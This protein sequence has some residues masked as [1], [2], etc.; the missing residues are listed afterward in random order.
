MLRIAAL[1]LPLIAVAVSPGTAQAQTPPAQGQ[2]GQPARPGAPVP[3]R[4]GECA[5][6]P[7]GKAPVA[8]IADLAQPLSP[9]S[10]DLVYFGKRLADL[11]HADFERIG[12]LSQKCGPAADLLSEEKV[13]KLEAVVMEAQKARGRTIAWAKQRMTEVLALPP[14]RDKLV[15]LNEIWAELPGREGTMT[16]E[17]IDGLAAWIANEQQTLY[18]A[19]SRPRP[20]PPAPAQEAPA[21][22]APPAA[23]ASA[24]AMPAPP[25]AAKPRRPGGEEE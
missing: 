10:L 3:A 6:L 20:G 19:A 7:G 17:D 23:G 9:R 16:R 22:G 21:P 8:Q 13:A 25:P 24:P 15:K 11:T 4:T 18:D 12:V 14:G 5:A 2:S 1:A